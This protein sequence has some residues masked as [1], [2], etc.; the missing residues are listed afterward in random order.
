MQIGNA[1][2]EDL[3]QLVSLLGLLFAQE[4]EFVPEPAKQ[5]RALAAILSDPQA[6]R[7]FAARDDGRVVAMASLLYTISTA[8]GGRAALFED[9]VVLPAYRGRGIGSA[10]LAHV[11]EQARHEGVLR[12]TL[13]TDRDNERAQALYRKCGFAESSMKPMRL[14]LGARRR[15]SAA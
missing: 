14:E 8:Q 7:I 1:R 10:L 6:G 12:L 4:K 15:S 2:L 11:V 9:L 5:E 13:L 3:P